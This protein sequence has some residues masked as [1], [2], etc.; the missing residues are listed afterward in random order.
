MATAPKPAPTT[1]GGESPKVHPKTFFDDLS[2]LFK[3]ASPLPGEEVRYAEALCLCDA[4]TNDPKL[5]A[6]IVDEA[7]RYQDLDSSG[8]R[9]NGGKRGLLFVH[10]RLLGGT[11]RARWHVDATGSRRICVSVSRQDSQD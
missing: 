1:G 3:D 2:A 8:Q 10:S 11:V 4:A 7:T 9:L 5:K 6:A